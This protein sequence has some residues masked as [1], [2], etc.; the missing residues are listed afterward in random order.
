MI[1]KLNKISEKKR[2]KRKDQNTRCKLSKEKMIF[3][4]SCEFEEILF[5][6]LVK[7]L[8]LLE[9]LEEETSNPQS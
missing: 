1:R 6:C 9:K 2:E 8:S 3:S 4:R 5:F 7:K